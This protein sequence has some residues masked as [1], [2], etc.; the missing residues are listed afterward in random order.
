MV[1]TGRLPRIL[2][3]QRMIRPAVEAHS[4][5]LPI[6]FGCSHGRCQFCTI[7]EGNPF[8]IR[9]LEEVKVDIDE[10]AGL[11]LPFNR[12]F[13]TDGD[14]LVV[15]H[16]RL[17]EV[18]DYIRQRLPWVE[19]VG[20][21]GNAKDILRRTPDQLRELKEH[22]LGIIYQGVES[23]DD[24]VLA[25]MEKGCTGLQ[26][27]AA[28]RRVR[29]AGLLLSVTIVLGLGG[30]SRSR[31]HALNTA[32]VLTAMRP[33]SIRMHTIVVSPLAPL[34]R[35]FKDGDFTPPDVWG[36]LAELRLLLEHVDLWDTPLIGNMKSNYLPVVGLLANERQ[37]LLDQVNTILETRDTSRLRSEAE[38]A[39]QF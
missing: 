18:L 31:D 8:R 38:R 28:G 6:T 19:R 35:A 25:A 36:I 11:G 5:I 20:I 37:P 21:Y 32:R 29:E 24:D 10:V 4:L 1:S 39:T 12:V 14:A 26:Q 22:N 27:V 13:I 16:E 17:L 34:H 3:Y 9:P 30:V 2:Q 33:S 23:G 7:N 15:R